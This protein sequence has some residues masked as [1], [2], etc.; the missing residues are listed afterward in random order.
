MFDDSAPYST[1]RRVEQQQ[2]TQLLPLVCQLSLQL[3]TSFLSELLY[4]LALVVQCLACCEQ[5]W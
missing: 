3:V 4:S 5:R 1:Q 2:V